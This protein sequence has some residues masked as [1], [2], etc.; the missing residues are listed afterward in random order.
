MRVE[1][2]PQDL[3]AF[4]KRF[5]TEYLNSDVSVAELY[6]DWSE[7]DPKYFGAIAKP[8]LGMRCLR[9]DPWECTLS[10]ICSQ[11]NNIKRIT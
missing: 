3:D 9:Q 7:R 8:L 6:T 4:R 1:P 11:N 10:F 5:E 2:E